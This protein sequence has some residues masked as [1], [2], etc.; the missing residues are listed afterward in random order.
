MFIGSTPRGGRVLQPAR[1]DEWGL[2][3]VHLRFDHFR[4]RTPSSR[5]EP[6]FPTTPEGTPLTAASFRT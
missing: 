5:L 6:G 2:K 4:R 3:A 1:F